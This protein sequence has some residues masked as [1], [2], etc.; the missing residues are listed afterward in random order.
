MKPS[1]GCGFARP[2]GRSKIVFLGVGWEPAWLD[3]ATRCCFKQLNAARKTSKH[4][5]QSTD[6]NTVLM[7]DHRTWRWW[8]LKGFGAPCW[9]SWAKNGAV[10]SDLWGNGF[11]LWLWFSGAIS[12]LYS[13]WMKRN[14]CWWLLSSRNGKNWTLPTT[15]ASTKL[16][17]RLPAPWGWCLCCQRFRC[18]QGASAAVQK[19]LSPKWGTTNSLNSIQIPYMILNVILGG[20][21]LCKWYCFEPCCWKIQPQLDHPVVV[22]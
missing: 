22:Q 10:G 16:A 6:Q 11:G 13:S 4:R 8:V 5:I 18:Y 7:A 9:C 21:Q 12:F 15:W 2:S 19:G 3:D 17:L 1:Q 14:K 20:P